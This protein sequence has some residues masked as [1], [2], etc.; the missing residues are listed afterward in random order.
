MNVKSSLHH[1]MIYQYPIHR[2]LYHLNTHICIPFLSS[3]ISYDIYS[4]GFHSHCIIPTMQQA[5]STYTK[6]T[7][8]F[9][10]PS[11]HQES[12]TS[13]AIDNVFGSRSA[14]EKGRASAVQH[15]AET[16]KVRLSAVDCP[17]PSLL[18]AAA[19]RAVILTASEAERMGGKG[20]GR[21]GPGYHQQHSP[22]DKFDT[23]WR[24]RRGGKKAKT[25]KE[26]FQRKFNEYLKEKGFQINSPLLLKT[27]LGVT[28]LAFRIFQQ[29]FKILIWVRRNLMLR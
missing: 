6:P 25:Q 27:M 29:S 14:E 22:R 12:T 16:S 21:K 1:W 10:A 17:V 3:I 28:V 23:S 4:L 5:L 15:W 18:L 2:P 11:I 9:Q 13:T 8:L 24:P 7:N 19:S 20:P 26:L